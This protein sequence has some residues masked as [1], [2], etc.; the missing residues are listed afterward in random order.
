MSYPL[1]NGALINGAE[2]GD[3]ALA[4]EGIDLITYGSHTGVG[5]TTAG[6]ESI[7]ELGD[8]EIE[9]ALQV[10]GL[11]LISWGQH[12]GEHQV[13]I[14]PDGLDLISWGEHSVLVT[15]VAGDAHIFEMGDVVVQI[16]QDRE[17]ELPGLDLIRWGQ[18]TAEVGVVLPSNGFT[19]AGN[20]RF[21]ELGGLAV[22]PAA[23]E[24]TAGAAHIFE[25][26]TLSV[27][28]AGTA[29]AAHIFEM[30]G[31]SVAAAVEAGGARIFE[32][33]G[34]S[35]GMSFTMQG[36]DLISHGTHTAVGGNM[37]TTAGDAHIFELGGLA[38]LGFATT[39]RQAFIF[40]LG[41]PSINRGTA[42]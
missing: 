38:P 7:F 23:A 5:G 13:D 30:G 1:I 11:D 41:K 6:G 25:M 17:L 20:A 12:V 24:T 3:F 39:A 42:C 36:M 27:G 14:T 26:G 29:G 4:P 37:A 18:H 40:E 10:P 15:P 8:F 28:A 32:L 16:G 2:G 35:V 21:F 34:L 9:F 19:V 22:V 31:L 33:G